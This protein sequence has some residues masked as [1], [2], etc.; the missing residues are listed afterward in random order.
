MSGII[1]SHEQWLQ[2]SIEGQ[3]EMFRRALESVPK[4]IRP[5]EPDTTTEAEEH[6]PDQLHQPAA[7]P[8]DT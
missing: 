7:P 5:A 4:G 2:M 6:A 1:D 8:Q 3:R